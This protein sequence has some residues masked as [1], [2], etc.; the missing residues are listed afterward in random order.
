MNE[1]AII[2]KNGIVYQGGRDYIYSAWSDIFDEDNPDNV[3]R[4]GNLMLVNI[5]DVQR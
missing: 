1:Y 3:E 5:I 2:D 4:E